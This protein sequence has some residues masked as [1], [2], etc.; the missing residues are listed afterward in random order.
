[1]APTG[2]VPTYQE[3]LS[4]YSDMEEATAAASSYAA[5]QNMRLDAAY[6]QAR[7]VVGE[8]SLYIGGGVNRINGANSS[9]AMPSMAL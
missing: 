6:P 2:A 4:L 8:M 9:D 5:V 3:I 1:M 7:P